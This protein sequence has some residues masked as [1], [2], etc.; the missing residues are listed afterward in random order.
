MISLFLFSVFDNAYKKSMVKTPSNKLSTG[1]EGIKDP[2]FSGINKINSNKK[3]NR[4][5]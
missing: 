4:Y 1:N 5:F 2:L 3:R